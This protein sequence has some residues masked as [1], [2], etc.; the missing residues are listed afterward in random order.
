LGFGG[1]TNDR[2][3]KHIK[4][5]GY[6]AYGTKDGTFKHSIGTAV[7]LNTY[8]NTWL[9]VSYTNDVREIGTTLFSVDKR[10]YK[11]YDPRPINISTFITMKRGEH[12]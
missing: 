10:P 2:F 7:N 11:I 1:V 12:F 8:S 3:S 6:S 4:I 5:N 9:S